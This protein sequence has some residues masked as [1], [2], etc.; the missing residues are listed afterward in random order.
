MCLV[1]LGSILTLT[2]QR[3]KRTPFTKVNYID[4]HP[5]VDVDGDWVK[6]LSI[7]GIPIDTFIAYARD[8]EPRDWTKGFHRY[9]HY[10][11]DDLGLERE[12]TVKVVYEIEGMANTKD[13]TLAV[14]NRELATAHYEKQRSNN[15]VKRNHIVNIPND[16]SYLIKRIDGHLVKTD[17]LTPDEAIHDLEYLEW[18]IDNHYSYTNLTGFNYKLALD[19]I[20]QGLEEGITKRDFAYQLKMF[21]ANFGDGHSSLSFYNTVV[22]KEEYKWLPFRIVKHGERFYG[23]KPESKKFYEDNYPLIESING[24]S[25]GALYE[26]AKEMVPKSTSKYV[27]RKSVDYLQ[28]SLLMIKIAGSA[29]SDEVK[30]TF[31]NSDEKK[32]STIALGQYR[33]QKLKIEERLRDT[34]L[35][36]NIAYLQ[37]NDRMSDD[38]GFV[39]SLN[40]AMQNYKST[41]GLIIDIRNNG[42]GSRMPLK[43]LLPYFIKDPKVVNVSRFRVDNNKDLG[44]KYGY[45]QERYSYPFDIDD[46]AIG[47]GEGKLVTS[48][49]RNTVARFRHDF[50][51]SKIVNSERYS[52]YHYMVVDPNDNVDAYYYNKPVVVLVDE[53]CFSASDIFAAGMKDGDQVTLI[54]NTTGG[55][56]GFTQRKTLPQSKLTVRL[57]Q[58]FSYQPDGNLYDG[59]GV[60]PHIQSD[61]T[62]EDKMGL[63][64]SQLDKAIGFLKVKS[65]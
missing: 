3:D 33:L 42:G 4:N 39:D 26:L 30:V 28:L 31:A 56:S 63:T 65:K 54:G 19:A 57:S 16:L 5:C 64:D 38:D 45:L 41:D 40:L 14:E 1:L 59:H 11:M 60:L 61:Y 34:V 43:V 22:T 15:R 47:E 7:E 52:D 37:F 8:N 23:I 20:R 36:N 2:A 62:L 12:E 18:E 29:T 48:S 25:I 58:M 9:L 13:F 32:V 51:P 17:W 35:Q 49:F 46:D 44:P 24:M 10:A 50:N 55:G 6:L 21:M 27:E 53:G